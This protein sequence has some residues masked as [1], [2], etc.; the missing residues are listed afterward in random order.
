MNNEQYNQII[1][2]AYKSYQKEINRRLENWIDIQEGDIY[3]GTS[4]D[5][6]GRVWTQEEFIN[7]IKTDSEF[8]EK[9]GL[10]IEER[11]LTFEER[12]DL[13][14]KYGYRTGD[15]EI[16]SP[17]SIYLGINERQE[18]ESLW[19]DPVIGTNLP[20]KLITITYKDKTIESYE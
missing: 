12:W 11:E 17:D 10:K 16:P 20:T 15:V 4:L 6:S 3:E 19:N 18:L 1:D 9:W 13:S 2:D 5:D 14:K 7:K 8:S